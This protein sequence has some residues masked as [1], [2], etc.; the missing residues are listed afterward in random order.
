YLTT[1]LRELD[2]SVA[3]HHEEGFGNNLVARRTGQGHKRIVLIGH[4]DT[5]YAAGSALSHALR[6]EDGIAYGPGVI[7]M[8]SG[9]LM[10]LTTLQVLAEAGFTDYGE[11]VVV[12]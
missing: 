11:V 6:V 7:D 2:F 8:K 10:C 12:F 9:V 3:L 4:V 5:V 1:W